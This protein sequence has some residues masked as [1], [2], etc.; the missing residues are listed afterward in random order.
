[1]QSRQTMSKPCNGIGFSRTRTVLYQIIF[2]GTIDFDIC[3]Q[4]CYHIQLM[5]ARKNHCFQY[6]FTC[7]LIL[8]HFQMKIFVQDFKQTLFAKNILPKIRCI[9][10]PFID[11]ISFSSDSPCAVTPLIKWQ[12]ICLFSF[13]MRSHINLCQIYCKMNKHTFFKRKNSIFSPTVKLILF[14]RICCALS[15]KLTL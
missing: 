6:D 7:I 12:K 2:T 5:I 1:M 13:Q 15:R 8:F 10:S 3:K 4:L 9:I 11:R 14:N